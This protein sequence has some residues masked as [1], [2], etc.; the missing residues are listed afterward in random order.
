MGSSELSEWMKFWSVEPWGPYR[1]NIHAGLIAA[2]IANVYRKKNTP[3]LTYEDFM[4]LDK[5]DHKKRETLKTL[6]WMKS[7][8]RR[9]NG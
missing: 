2:T 5:E 8:A 3:A 4:L 1:D 9:K 6:N 7:V